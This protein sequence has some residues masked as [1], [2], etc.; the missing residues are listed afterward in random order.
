VRLR[1]HG[2]AALLPTDRDVDLRII[3]GVERR[4]ITLA[5][6]AEDVID[7]LRKKLIDQDLAAGAEGRCHDWARERWKGR[8]D[9]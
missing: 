8:G 7:S 3:E 9:W 6:H 1:H 5:R 2:G 4:Q